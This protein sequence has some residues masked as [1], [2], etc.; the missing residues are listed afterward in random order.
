MTQVDKR[1]C[2]LLDARFNRDEYLLRVMFYPP[3]VGSMIE[4]ILMS[5]AVMAYPPRMRV[6][7]LEFYLVR[8]YWCSQTIEYQETSTRCALVYCTYER[9][10]ESLSIRLGRAS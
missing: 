6:Y 10:L 4:S 9:I 7:L 8:G 5:I 3:A 2:A 1:L